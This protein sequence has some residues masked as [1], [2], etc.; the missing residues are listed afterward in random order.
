MTED[1]VTIEPEATVREAARLHRAQEAQPAAGRRARPARRRGHAAR[2]ARRPRA[3][4]SSRCCGRSP[5]IDLGAI[6]RNCARS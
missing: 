6:S 1:P 2:R 5:G 4:R 3:T